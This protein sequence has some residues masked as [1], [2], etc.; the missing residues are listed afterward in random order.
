[1]TSDAVH[2]GR[3]RKENHTMTVI[4]TSLNETVTELAQTGGL[5]AVTIDLYRNIHKGIR[6][7]LFALTGGAGNLDPADACGRADLAAYVNSVTDLLVGHAAHEDEVIQPA[8]LTHLPALAEKIERDHEVIERR[9]VGLRVLAEGAAAA[10]G[11]H[12]DR[13][14]RLYL[15][16]ASFTSAYLAHQDVEERVVMPALEAAVG[17]DAVV[18]MHIAIVSSIP[19]DEMGRALAVMLPA[20]N[21]DDRAELLG[22]MRDS[23]PAE[24]FDGVWSLARS[25]LAAPDSAALASRLAIA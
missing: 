12:R 20:M 5:R 18:A 10:T 11:D 8:L 19:P 24:V 14:H 2:G 21:I 17:V 22:G 1:M 16:L 25:V 13:V 6:A 23:A 15:E 3:T 9:I 7:E 4:E